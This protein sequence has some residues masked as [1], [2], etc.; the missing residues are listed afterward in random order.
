MR[1][2]P[3]RWLPRNLTSGIVAS[4]NFWLNVFPKKGGISKKYGPRAIMFGTVIDYNR[5]CQVVTG[6]YVEIHEKT[7][8]MLKLRTEPALYL[9]PLGNA[10]GGAYYMKISNGERVHRNRYTMIP[11]PE[12]VV[13]KVHRLANR[14]GH[15]FTTV[16][17]RAPGKRQVK[18]NH[19][20]TIDHLY[21]QTSGH[22]QAATHRHEPNSG[23]D[24]TV[25]EPKGSKITLEYVHAMRAVVENHKARSDCHPNEVLKATVLAQQYHITKGLKIYGDRGREAV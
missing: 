24:Y 21:T 16:P 14:R 17:E 15:D 3:F 25:Q 11:M 2:L 22:F 6:Q 18:K 4:R 23:T 1:K 8:N 13:D 12:D 9:Y 7:D 5:H 10:K 19:L 20:R